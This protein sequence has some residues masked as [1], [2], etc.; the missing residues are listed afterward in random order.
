MAC[1]CVCMN[2]RKAPL[3]GD[4]FPASLK[5]EG[6][7]ELLYSSV[8]EFEIAFLYDDVLNFLA[9]RAPVKYQFG[10]RLVMEIKY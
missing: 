1:L 9:Q 3:L 10:T 4:K 7:S 2:F 8:M 5:L 6:V